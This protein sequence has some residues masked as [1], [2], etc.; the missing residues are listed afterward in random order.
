MR[1]RAEKLGSV[2]LDSGTPRRMSFVG[3]P[4]TAEI[5]RFGGNPCYN[6]KAAPISVDAARQF[7]FD[8]AMCV[9]AILLHRRFSQIFPA[10]IRCITVLVIDNFGPF[11]RLYH[12]DQ[13]MGVK[14][15]TFDRNMNITPALWTTSRLASKFPIP[16]VLHHFIGEVTQGALPPRQN[17]CRWIVG[18]GLMQVLCARQWL[19]HWARSFASVARAVCGACHTRRPDFY[20]TEVSL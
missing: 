14:T 2:S 5:N 15:A 13:T 10:I 3:R 16:S 9:V 6:H 4:E 11:A 19:N 7:S 20:P 18:Q 1:L 17:A 12:P 8:A